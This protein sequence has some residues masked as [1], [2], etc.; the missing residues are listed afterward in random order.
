MGRPPGGVGQED[1]IPPCLFSARPTAKRRAVSFASSSALSTS[2]LACSR[3]AG[4]SR[5][6]SLPARSQPVSSVGRLL[7]LDR[8]VCCPRPWPDRGRD[9]VAARPQLLGDRL[10]DPTGIAETTAMGDETVRGTPPLRAVVS[11]AGAT[12]CSFVSERVVPGPGLA[13][14]RQD[15][16]GREHRPAVVDDG[17][18]GNGLFGAAF[19][20]G[21]GHARVLETRR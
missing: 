5:A 12:A 21:F 9:K 15:L 11:A 19:Q 13:Q 20:V 7:P 4:E 18:V 8:A 2:A 1:A 16:F 14:D 17:S 10:C 6:G 3:R